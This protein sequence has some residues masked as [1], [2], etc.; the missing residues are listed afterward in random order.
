MSPFAPVAITGLI[1]AAVGFPLIGWFILAELFVL[2]SA[3][4]SVLTG[5]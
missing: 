3:V 2:K 5:E 1:L 4:E